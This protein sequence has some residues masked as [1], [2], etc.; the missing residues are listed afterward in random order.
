MTSDGRRMPSESVIR[1]HW[2][3]RLWERKGFDSPDEF[4]EVGVC[5]ACGMNGDN[6]GGVERCHI[7]ARCCGGSDD[8]SNLHMLCRICHKDSEALDGERYWSW[9]FE[10]T[11]LDAA[12]SILARN[13]VNLHSQYLKAM[14][15]RSA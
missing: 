5:F 3:D 14:G 7:L 2:A 15:G 1:A 12:A 4:R 10:R 6:V 8:A 9:F 13:G 11:W